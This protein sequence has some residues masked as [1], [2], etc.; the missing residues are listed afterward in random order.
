VTYLLP[1]YTLLISLKQF[2]IIES[3]DKQLP[4]GHYNVVIERTRKVR[5]KCQRK[6]HMRVIDGKFVGKTI[7]TTI[8]EPPEA[9]G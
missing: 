7:T 4:P 9:K 5:N 6:L 2:Y 8:P 1:K 3:M